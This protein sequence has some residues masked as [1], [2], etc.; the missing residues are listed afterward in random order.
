MRTAETLDHIAAM[1]RRIDLVENVLATVI[2]NL[3]KG[4]TAEELL[5]WWDENKVN[6]QLYQSRLEK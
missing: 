2:V 5:T 1:Q 3:R 4:C 6:E